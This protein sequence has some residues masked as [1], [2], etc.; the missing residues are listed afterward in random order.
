MAFE[1]LRQMTN[2][3]RRS[4]RSSDYL[5]KV[6]CKQGIMKTKHE[7]TLFPDSLQM[8]SNRSCTN[9]QHKKK[10]IIKEVMW[11]RSHGYSSDAPWGT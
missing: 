2:L 4:I 9:S 11:R 1:L 5:M 8:E 10:I 7:D 6:Q 3:V